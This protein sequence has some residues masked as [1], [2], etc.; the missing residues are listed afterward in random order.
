M[1]SLAGEWTNNGTRRVQLVTSALVC[2]KSAVKSMVQQLWN[3]F[4]LLLLIFFPSKKRKQ[5][6]GNL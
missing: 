4:F 2:L 3:Y 5:T 6:N 1:L